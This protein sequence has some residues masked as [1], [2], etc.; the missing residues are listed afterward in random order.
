MSLCWANP[1]QTST[2]IGTLC[3]M[4]NQTQRHPEKVIKAVKRAAGTGATGAS[5][6]TQLEDGS[7]AYAG[8]PYLMPL[9]TVRYYARQAKREAADP[10]RGVSTAVQ[11]DALA[12]I[13]AGARQLLQF[14]L[15]QV[16][17]IRAKG[18][19]ADPKRALEVLE[20]LKKCREL[21]DHKPKPAPRGKAKPA[22]SVDDFAA[23]LGKAAAARDTA[24]QQPK[25]EEEGTSDGALHNAEGPP[26][27]GLQ[28]ATNTEAQGRFTS[29]P[30]DQ[31][32]PAW[33]S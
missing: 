15:D 17:V 28:H 26:N 7:L 9:S 27:H 4:P 33:P 5:I 18:D 32:I 14:A 10:V 11:S 2:I 16:A 19:K 30:S 22:D 25:A 20:M 12:A 31:A 21:A 24:P 13:D 3:R 6:Q 29:T 23:R 1:T 8:G